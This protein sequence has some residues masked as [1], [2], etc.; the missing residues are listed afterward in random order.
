MRIR[1]SIQNHSIACIE[2]KCHIQI[3]QEMKALF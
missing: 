3:D 1:M 2:E